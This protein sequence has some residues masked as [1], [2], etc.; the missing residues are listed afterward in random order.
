MENEGLVYLIHFNT[1]LHHARHYLGFCENGIKQRF[2]RHKASQG[3]KLL[4]ALNEKGIGYRIV[5]IW[6][7]VDRNFER[8]LKNKKSTP[9]LCPI[10]NPKVKR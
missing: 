8:S 5:R 6:R 4:K 10:C 9:K 1:P 2:E 3:A 7:H